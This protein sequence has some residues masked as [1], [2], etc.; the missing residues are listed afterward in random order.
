MV[1]HRGLPRACHHLPHRRPSRCPLG[2]APHALLQ[3]TGTATPLPVQLLL[4][5]WSA[6]TASAVLP[7]LP[8]RRPHLHPHLPTHLPGAGDNLIL[9]TSEEFT[10]LS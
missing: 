3:P 10:L 4:T 8:G 1:P 2:A 6:E 5:R 9:S 7:A